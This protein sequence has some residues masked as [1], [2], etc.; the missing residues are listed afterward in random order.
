[1]KIQPVNCMP[2]YAKVKSANPNFEG[3]KGAILGGIGLGTLLTAAF[4]TTTGL[5]GLVGW[6]LGVWVAT[7]G[8]VGG[9]AAGDHYEDKIKEKFS[10]NKTN[11][12]PHLDTKA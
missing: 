8:T 7:A 10:K 5:T 11:D 9:A 6:A 3:K 12:N 2:N 1:M 4:V